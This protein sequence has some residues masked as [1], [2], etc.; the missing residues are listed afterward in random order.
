MRKDGRKKNEKRITNVTEDYLIHPDGSV[1]IEVGNT[2]VICSAFIEEKVPHFLKGTESGWITAEYSMI[3]GSTQTR[4]VRDSSRGKIDGRT[5]EIQRLI[6]RSLR[7]VVDLKKL[8]ERTIWMDC[9]VIQADGGTRTASITG[10]FIALML[11]LKK[12]KEQGLIDEIPV[13]E[14]VAAIS[15]GVVGD[16][17]CLD[18]CYEEDSSAKVDMNLVMT[19]SGK[20]IEIQG[21]GEESSF[22]RAEMNQMMDLAEKG[23]LE[24]INIQ[25]DVLN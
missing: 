9:D 5:H 10:S 15:V 4:K 16:E 7:A 8:G 19:E 17:V 20:I 24:L 1:L 2:K 13:N 22:S 14:Y 12:L 18:L 3:P 25:K 6:G 23:I 11:A 21:T